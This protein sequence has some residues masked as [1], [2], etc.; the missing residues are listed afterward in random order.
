MDECSSEDFFLNREYQRYATCFIKSLFHK[1]INYVLYVSFF[2]LSRES[3]CIVPILFAAQLISFSQIK[4]WKNHLL[5]SQEVHGDGECD[6]VLQ[7][8]YAL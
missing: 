5:L 2:H 3:R 1:L 6:F 8:N 4:V 7:G